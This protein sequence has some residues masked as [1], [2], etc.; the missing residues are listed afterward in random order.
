LN[1]NGRNAK[2]SPDTQAA[3]LR[4]VRCRTSRNIASPDRTN[5]DAITTLKTNAGG[6]PAQDRGAAATE[7]ASIVSLN[8]SVRRSG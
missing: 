3:S 1:R 7:G 5:P 2:A 4:P 6:A 8:A